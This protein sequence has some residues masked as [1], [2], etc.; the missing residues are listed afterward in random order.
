VDQPTRASP[1]PRGRGRG[2]PV[3]TAP[4]EA[5]IFARLPGLNELSLAVTPDHDLGV[6]T[7]DVAGLAG[8]Y[9]VILARNH[10]LD[11]ANWLLHA[12]IAL[13]PPEQPPADGARPPSSTF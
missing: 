5:D 1:P 9:Q 3:I 12:C 10:V 13:K 6:V 11:L 7:I 2:G 4:D 8:A